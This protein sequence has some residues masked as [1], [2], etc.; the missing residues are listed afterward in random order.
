MHE[1]YLLMRYFL[2]NLLINR[3]I[4]TTKQFYYSKQENTIGNSRV[5]KPN[6]PMACNKQISG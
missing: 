5:K 1:R 3:K 4:K 2:F 6:N